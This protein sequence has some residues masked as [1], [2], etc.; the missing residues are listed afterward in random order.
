MDFQ[1][2]KDTYVEKVAIY[3]CTVV[4]LLGLLH[5]PLIGSDSSIHWRSSSRKFH[6]KLTNFL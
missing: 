2:F 5:R 3:R 1:A 4:S 6:V